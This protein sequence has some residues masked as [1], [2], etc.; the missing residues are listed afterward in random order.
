MDTYAQLERPQVTLGE[1]SLDL[2]AP[3]EM[4]SNLFSRLRS[5]GQTATEKMYGLYESATDM[6]RNVAAVAFSTG[7]AAIGL[8]GGVAQTSAEAY[9]DGLG[10]T[11][12]ALTD[13]SCAQ[14][15]LQPP[16]NLRGRYD[17][18]TQANNHFYR[19]QFSVP[20]VENCSAL[21]KRTVHYFQ[22][23]NRG[24]W[25]LQ[26]RSI[27]SNL[28]ITTKSVLNINGEDFYLRTSKAK[29]VNN[30]FRAAHLCVNQG[31]GLT[32]ID[33]KKHTLGRPTAII[34]WTPS[35]GTPSSAK[36]F[37]GKASPLCK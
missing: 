34:T 29:T 4:E 10:H 32:D 17:S 14:E 5:L 23:I 19:E 8:V 36:T 22:E 35:D 16:K 2:E 6:S 25:V 3:G 12:A 20:S 13:A 33:K 9:P 26:Q 30:D 21:G 11:S 1:A 7:V 37:Y 27:D 31:G 24:G 28:V 15:A 18:Y